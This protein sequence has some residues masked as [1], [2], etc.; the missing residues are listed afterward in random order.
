VPSSPPWRGCCP[1]ACG[2]AAATRRE[3]ARRPFDRRLTALVEE[4]RTADP[5]VARWWDDHTVHDCASVAKRIDHPQA[6]QLSAGPAAA[7]PGPQRRRRARPECGRRAADLP[8]R[9]VRAR[10]RTGAALPEDRRR[11]GTPDR[12]ARSRFVPAAAPRRIRAAR[13]GAPAPARPVP[14]ET[15]TQPDG[16]HWLFWS[17]SLPRVRRSGA[18]WAGSASGTSATEARTPISASS[19]SAMGPV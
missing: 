16:D 9:G 6:G 14:P 11:R 8:G 13:A 12:A 17:L 2:C 5:D 19:P 10:H 4:L 7:R 18:S 15:G 1:G 3:A